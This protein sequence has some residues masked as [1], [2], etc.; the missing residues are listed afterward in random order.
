[1][2]FGFGEGVRPLW[3]YRSEFKGAEVRGAACKAV[4]DA[5]DHDAPIYG[6]AR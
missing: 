1:M 2:V 5:G 4:V 6:R 3:L